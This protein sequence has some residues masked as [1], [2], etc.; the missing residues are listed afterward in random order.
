MRKLK[1]QSTKRPRS[2]RKALLSDRLIDSND[3]LHS[4]IENLLSGVS[5]RERVD[6]LDKLFPRK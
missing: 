4:S 3:P 5:P 2:R 6:Q 1:S